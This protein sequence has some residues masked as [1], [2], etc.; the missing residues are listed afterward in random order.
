MSSNVEAQIFVTIINYPRGITGGTVDYKSLH[1]DLC[2]IVKNETF[3]INGNSFSAQPEC[4]W[5]TIEDDM[6]KLSSMYTGMLF[7]V[8]SNVPDYGEDPV[9]DYFYEGKH[10]RAVLTFSPFDESK[11]K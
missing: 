3:S 9:Q 8:K 2:S 5:Y 4:R 10:Q 7:T 1:Q 11:L 6:K